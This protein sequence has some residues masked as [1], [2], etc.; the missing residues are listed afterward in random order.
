MWPA[1]AGHDRRL[2]GLSILRQPLIALAMITVLVPAACGHV[3]ARQVAE[4]APQ[5]PHR[6]QP[7]KRMDMSETILNCLCVSALWRPSRR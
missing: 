5:R 2:A 3:R 7:L 1:V 4:Q 6:H